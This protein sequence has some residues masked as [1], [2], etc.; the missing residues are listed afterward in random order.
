MLAFFEKG[1]SLCQHTSVC[2]LSWDK[3]LIKIFRQR[4]KL[5]F[6]F[7]EKTLDL[8]AKVNA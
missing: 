7:V 2:S 3:V 6:V 4:I 5:L 8:V 1:E